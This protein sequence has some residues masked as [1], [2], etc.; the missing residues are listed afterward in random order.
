MRVPGDMHTSPYVMLLGTATSVTIQQGL[1]LPPPS[2]RNYHCSAL[3]RLKRKMVRPE[4]ISQ[5][6]IINPV[7]S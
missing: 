1:Q 2:E 7:W 6:R 4:A 5:G 3:L